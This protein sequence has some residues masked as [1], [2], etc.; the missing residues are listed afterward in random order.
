MVF[1]Y[2]S[3][4][5]YFRLLGT[6]LLP[7]RPGRN[8][9]TEQNR[10]CHVMSSEKLG[11]YLVGHPRVITHH[12]YQARPP[13]LDSWMDADWTG[14]LRTRRSASGGGSKLWTHMLQARLENCFAVI[15]RERLASKRNPRN[16]HGFLTCDN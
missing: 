6:L 7:L 4:L 15:L 11:R 1:H 5:Y 14:C 9:A 10:N 16:S 12:P 8:W 3:G 2:F 13:Y